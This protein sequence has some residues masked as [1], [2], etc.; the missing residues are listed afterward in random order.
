MKNFVYVVKLKDTKIEKSKE[1][2][3]YSTI[4]Y[5]K[6]RGVSVRLNDISKSMQNK[7]VEQKVNS[8]KNDAAYKDSD[9]MPPYYILVDE[10]IIGQKMYRRIDD[11]DTD[12]GIDNVEFIKVYSYRC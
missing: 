5:L 12:L 11:L 10:N 3:K 4:D 9:F 7:F 1:K 6:D 8:I 2:I